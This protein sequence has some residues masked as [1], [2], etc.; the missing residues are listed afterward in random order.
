MDASWRECNLSKGQLKAL[1]T[2]MH[3][4]E[5]STVFRE[6]RIRGVEKGDG[7]LGSFKG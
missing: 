3:R 6:H 1:Y 5:H 2:Q 4:K 7:L